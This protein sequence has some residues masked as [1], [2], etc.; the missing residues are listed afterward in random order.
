MEYLETVF[1][2]DGDKELV[3]TAADLL[4]DM[5]ADC[6]FEAFTGEGSDL[7]GFVQTEQFDKALL[8]NIIADFPFDGITITYDIKQAPNEDWNKQWEDEGFEPIEIGEKC[9]VYDAKHTNRENLSDS[10]LP[11]FIDARQAFG[12][13]T[14]ETTR[15]IVDLL[16]K[17]DMKGKN[18][19][20]CGCG[21]GILGIAA[22][23]LGAEKVV[24]YDIDEWSVDNTRHNAEINEVADRFEVLH[25]NATVLNHV[26][27]VF[28]IVMANI[29]RKIL[30]SDIK[31]F[32][33][34]MRHGT[35]LII[36]GFYAE[37]MP[38]LID[39]AQKHDLS[40]I[41]HVTDNNWACMEFVYK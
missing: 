26:S 29:N 1:N 21:T 24:A 5:A 3:N 37:D 16:T 30:I 27:G 39:E 34:A 9:V 28:D 36:S 31:S 7:V 33:T 41:Y 12:T 11:I 38:M 19:L 4:T 32:C 18:V 25:G 22:A 6:G 8:D 40:E 2:I 23:K 14:H 15:M 17:T 20:D 35:A 10:R 13:G